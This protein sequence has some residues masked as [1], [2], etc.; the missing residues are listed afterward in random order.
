MA[1]ENMEHMHECPEHL[2]KGTARL[3]EDNETKE[4]G[5]KRRMNVERS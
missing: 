5:K 1:I 3:K 4:V 2:R